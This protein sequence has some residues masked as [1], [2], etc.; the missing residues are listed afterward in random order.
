M[1]VTKDNTNL[2][3]G[4]ALLRELADLVHDLV[5][6]GLQPGWRSAR[7]R[8]RGAGDTLSLAVKTTHVGGIGW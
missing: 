2:R 5:G 8:E 1:A 6:R 4:G 7:V 3:R